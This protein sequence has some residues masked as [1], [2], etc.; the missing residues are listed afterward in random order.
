MSKILSWPILYADVLRL[1]DLESPVGVA[2]MWTERM[3]VAK[4]LES[5]SY[6]VIGNLY[7]TAGISPLIRNIFAKPTIN[8]LIL[9][10]ADLSG[11]GQAFLNFMK[12]GVDKD[13]QIKGDENRGLI[14]KE[15]DHKS[16]ELF[17][18]SVEL[19]NLK[20]KPVD[21][22]KKTV[23]TLAKIPRG[24]TKGFTKPKLFPTQNPK[25]FT[26]PSEQSGYIVNVEKAARG[27]LK[28]L[29]L[30]MRYGRIKK[31]RYAQN[32]ELK[33]ILNLTVT[34]T[35]E[36]AKDPYFPN[37]FLFSQKE[38]A[39][40]LPQVLTPKNIPGI[41]YSYGQRLRDNQ[42][43]DQI[44]E[45]IE[46]A[47]R[48]PFSKK[49]AAFTANI[50][51]DWG[52]ENIDRGDTPC[53]TQVLCSIQDGKLF[54]TTHFR[55]QDM[56]HGWP[57]NVLSLIKLQDFICKE[58]KV[59]RGSF[60]MITHSAH[61][62][63]DDFRKI[64]K[65]LSENFE[66]ELGFTSRQHFRNDPRGNYTVEV[67]RKNKLILVK[68]F[69]PD[70]GLM[71]KQ[72]H[73]ETALQLIWEITDWDYFALPSHA[74]YVGSELQRAENALVNGTSYTQDRP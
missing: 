29:N 40:Y 36:N 26:Y 38:L 1:G 58:S 61:I 9:W 67:D 74:M 73:G 70:G 22:L 10:G 60:A 59:E 18:K 51:R 66:K 54:M 47:K 33:E 44:Q 49:M 55:S 56:V 20:G 72:W 53:L 15:I 48:R 35:D 42:G 16:L 69:A 2:T 24:G 17:R 45:I 23:L 4:A 32:N 63:A 14:E 65:I 62:Y 12:N 30:I 13:H 8:K 25:P 19:I 21:E 28:L 43:I 3:A 34:I 27:W 39:Q 52:R 57:R 46:L 7:S 31:T 37:Y 5:E 41:S 11:S 6:C 50:E 71:L 68:L 64:E